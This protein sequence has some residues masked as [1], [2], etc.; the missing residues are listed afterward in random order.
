[1]NIYCFTTWKLYNQF[2]YFVYQIL[3]YFTFLF[4]LLASKEGYKVVGQAAA[5]DT[6]EEGRR[7]WRRQGQEEEVVERKGPRQVEQSSPVR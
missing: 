1:M 5:E 3:T 2:N 6:K 4:S 7:R